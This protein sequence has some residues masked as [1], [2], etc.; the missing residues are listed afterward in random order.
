[1]NETA[2]CFFHWVQW[3][4]WHGI[5]L[6]ICRL[7]DPATSVGK[8]NLSICL[9]PDIARPESADR[10]RLLVRSAQDA[11]HFARVWRNRW[12]AHR[13]F[14][15]AIEDTGVQPLPDATI[16]SVREALAA[17]AA[18]LDAV[19][20]T[21]ATTAW[22]PLERSRGARSM[23]LYLEAGF[24]RLEHERELCEEGKLAWN[25]RWQSKL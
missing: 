6:Q 1:M 7:T 18:A 16:S 3:S 12:I 14:A 20:P 22:R 10:V 23:L 5:L 8:Q 25:D 2:G 4:M 21:G 13:D 17:I 11:S 9:L 19:D 24:D 15:V